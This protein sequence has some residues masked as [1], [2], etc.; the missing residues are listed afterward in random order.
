MVE[1]N[2]PVAGWWTW[3]AQTGPGSTAARSRGPTS[4]RATGS[5]G[6]ETVIE[7]TSRRARTRPLSRRSR[8]TCTTGE[9]AHCRRSPETM[10]GPSSPP[11]S[12][13]GCKQPHPNPP[14]AFPHRAV[15][16]AAI[17]PLRRLDRLRGTPEHRRRAS[18][19]RSACS[20]SATAPADRR[21]P[22]RPGAW[23]GRD[24]SRLPGPPRG[25][26]DAGRAEDDRAG[27]HPRR[28]GRGGSSA[29]R[30]S[31][32]QLDHPNIVACREVGEVQGQLYF[33]MEYVPGVDVAGSS[34]T[35]ADPCR[36]VGPLG[37]RASSSK[38]SNTPT[39]KSSSTATSS[40][41]T[42]W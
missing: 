35:M 10:G 6:D 22:D 32:A 38:L 42:C 19:A 13:G 40:R 15:G 34:R 5:R 29:R 30:T 26:R 3:G 41:R 33:A 16:S 31:F 11:L 23:P 39:P 4:R 14:P 24:G 2:P 28:G 12:P 36:S 7:L 21:I 25:R 27:D 37:S 1:V 9:G 17:R 20:R 8:R 18:S